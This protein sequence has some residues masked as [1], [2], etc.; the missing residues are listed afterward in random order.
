MDKGE[1]S[2]VPHGGEAE[3]CVQPSQPPQSL[4]SKECFLNGP[5]VKRFFHLSLQSTRRRKS[6][7]NQVSLVH[8][9]MLGSISHCSHCTISWGKG[10]IDKSGQT[11]QGKSSVLW[12]FPLGSWLQLKSSKS[13]G[14]LPL[15][16][17]RER[18]CPYRSYLL[19]CRAVSQGAGTQQG[20]GA[21][22]F[23]SWPLLPN[24]IY[25]EAVCQAAS[26]Q[27]KPS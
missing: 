5:D 2:P 6:L 10:I 3:L 21:L 18:W 7:G 16:E 24:H 26:A 15:K 17:A 14:M 11:L 9:C 1:K 25:S 12:W 8:V 4:H 27:I 13:S 22:P 19:L 20:L 23:Q